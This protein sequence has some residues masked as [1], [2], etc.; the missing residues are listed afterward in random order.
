MDFLFLQ[1][2]HIVN[3]KRVI[4]FQTVQKNF[5]K[6]KKNHAVK[7]PNWKH[8][9]MLQLTLKQGQRVCNICKENFSMEINIFLK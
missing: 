5:V 4:K 1:H 3:L 7:L 8:K 2:S 6:P 9:K